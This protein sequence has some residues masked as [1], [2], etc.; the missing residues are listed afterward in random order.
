MPGLG[1]EEVTFHDA[2]VFFSEEEWEALKEWQKELYHNVMKEVHQALLSLGP[3]IFTTVCSLRIKEKQ[4]WS[5]Q[6]AA[7]IHDEDP[8]SMFIHDLGDEI[9]GRSLDPDPDEDPAS[10]FIGCC[11]E[12]EEGRMLDPELGHAGITDMEILCIKEEAGDYS[13]EPHGLA[14]GS[15]AGYARIATMDTM[16]VKDEAAACSMEPHDA[17]TGSHEEETTYNGGKV[18]DID[19]SLTEEVSPQKKHH[20]YT[21][22]KHKYHPKQKKHHEQH[23]SQQKHEYQKRDKGEK[24][25]ISSPTLET[26]TTHTYLPV[27]EEPS[28]QLKYPQQREESAHKKLSE[29]EIP[30]HQEKIVTELEIFNLSQEKDEVD[31]SAVD[32][33]EKSTTSTSTITGQERKTSVQLKKRNTTLRTMQSHI[34]CS[35]FYNE[36]EIHFPTCT[37]PI[38]STSAI[39]SVQ[40]NAATLVPSSGI[41]PFGKLRSWLWKFFESPEPNDV[42]NVSQ[43]I[44]TICKVYLKRGNPQKY[45]L[46]NSAMLSHMKN[47]HKRIFLENVQRYKTSRSTRNTPVTTTAGG[48]HT[49]KTKHTEGS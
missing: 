35:S 13:M 27:Q 26:Q 9:G 33:P 8:A 6:E 5:S 39:G 25:I 28:V 10:I 49:H 1:S 16:G 36:K 17:A 11:K 18:Q 38:I 46:G 7:R 30:T 2:P 14:T 48:K 29:F 24:E 12:E 22:L 31:E 43:V 20:H 15:P 32:V 40:Q 37:L 21:P 4:D 47:K 44:C 23:H 41:V 3:L 34:Q 42:K 45:N 19:S